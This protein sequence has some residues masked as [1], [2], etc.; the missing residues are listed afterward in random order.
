[1]AEEH[2]GGDDERLHSVLYALAQDGREEAE[3]YEACEGSCHTEEW[4]VGVEECVPE[5]GR[6]C[7]IACRGG[8][9]FH[10]CLDFV[11]G[12]GPKL[13]EIAVDRDRGEC[14][15]M[16]YPCMDNLH[17]EIRIITELRPPKNK[18]VD[19]EDDCMCVLDKG[20]R[21]IRD[22]LVMACL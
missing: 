10:G 1:M 13:V 22:V 21:L 14:E 17:R 6:D 2:A 7:R 15:D 3:L 20:L 19:H 12:S 16:G 8:I 4:G 5:C 9:R 18:L 11:L